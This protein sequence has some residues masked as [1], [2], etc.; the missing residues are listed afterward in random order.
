MIAVPPPPVLANVNVPAPESVTLFSSSRTAFWPPPLFILIWPALIICVPKTES[1]VPGS[2]FRVSKVLPS[3]RSLMDAS[4]FRLTTEGAAIVP[5]PI[6]TFCVWLLGTPPIQFPPSPQSPV[7]AFQ[8]ES[9]PLS[10]HCPKAAIEQRHNITK[11]VTV[12]AN[13]RTTTVPLKFSV[14]GAQVEFIAAF[15]LYFIQL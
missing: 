15:L 3:C 4:M 2:K 7:P 6:Q 5:L 1:I 12:A 10:E 14:A 9:G 8:L 13:M 11:A